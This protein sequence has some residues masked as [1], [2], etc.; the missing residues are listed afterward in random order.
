MTTYVPEKRPNALLSLFVW[1]WPSSRFKMWMLRRLGNT[2]GN[3]VVIAPTVV[4]AC[5][6]FVIGDEVV[7]YQFNIF[8][9]LAG[10]R[11]GDK[12]TIGTMNQI[13]ASPA[14]QKYSKFVGQLLLEEQG[15]I[16]NRHY[17]DCSGQ[18][19][20][21]KYAA[22][23]GVKSVFQSHE[24][25]L[26]ED[27]TTIGR[28]IL[29]EYSI[30]TTSVI[31]L[32]DSFLPARSVLAAGALMG[33]AREGVELPESMLYAGVPA[34]PVAPVSDLAWWHRESHVTAVTPFD[35]EVFRLS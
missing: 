30:S 4:L 25:D 9:N 34:K 19:I 20:L 12:A 11:L 5:G 27:K 24:I 16:T 7:I 8:R 35:D 14:Y 1:L 29:G 6:P 22:I 32:K 2:I 28:V 3:N 33:K 17:L 10:V 13:T 26:A 21:R 18:I 15:G 23:G 31:M